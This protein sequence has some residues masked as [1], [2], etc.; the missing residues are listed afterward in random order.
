MKIGYVGPVEANDKNF[1][2][3]IAM[4]LISLFLV[5]FGGYGMF[6]WI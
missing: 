1:S 5:A 3:R 6:K 4:L 2:L